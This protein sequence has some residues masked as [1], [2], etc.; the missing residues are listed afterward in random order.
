MG[1]DAK[2]NRPP[3]DKPVL[4]ENADI[5]MLLPGMLINEKVD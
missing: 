5:Y 2:N 4:I 1:W 3:L